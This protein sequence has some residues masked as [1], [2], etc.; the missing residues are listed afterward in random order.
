MNMATETFLTTS[1]TTVDDGY[2]QNVPA[3][4]SGRGSRKPAF[5][6]SEVVTLSDERDGA[7]DLLDNCRR[8][9]V[10]GDKGFL[11]QKRQATLSEDQGLLLLTPERKNQCLWPGAA[12]GADCVRTVCGLC[13]DCVGHPELGHCQNHG[14][15]PRG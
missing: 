10:L 3:L 1:Y 15:D 5:S 2:Q 12:G 14:T 6:D 8:F 7:Q 13:T 4:I 9:C 11:D